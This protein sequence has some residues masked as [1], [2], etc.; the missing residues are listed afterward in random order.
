MQPS[1]PGLRAGILR[2]AIK[3]SARAL[4]FSQSRALTCRDGTSSDREIVRMG[5][6]QDVHVG[7]VGDAVQ[8]RGF[9]LWQVEWRRTSEDP[10]KLPHTRYRHQHHLFVIYEVGPLDDQV[11]FAAGELS[12]GVWGFYV[13]SGTVAFG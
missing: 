11:R 6:W 9:L 4:I 7:L 12:N 1:N 3:G 2:Q 10:I 8:I 5:E 13:P